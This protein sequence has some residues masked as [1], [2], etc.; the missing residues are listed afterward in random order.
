MIIG[1]DKINLV[2]SDEGQALKYGNKQLWCLCVE[3]GVITF[4]I[5]FKGLNN[6]E[7]EHIN[8]NIK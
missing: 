4:L 6:E 1:G 8:E 7:Y 2:A 3:C 5:R